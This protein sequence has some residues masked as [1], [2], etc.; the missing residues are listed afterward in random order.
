[1]KRIRIHAHKL[2][3]LAEKCEMTERNAQL[4]T[5]LFAEV[6][7]PSGNRKPLIIDGKQVFDD[8]GNPVTYRPYKKKPMYLDPEITK[9]LAAAMSQN[10]AN[11]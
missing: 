2:V 10:T 8:E 7:V 5:D 9:I 4:R 6:M 11:R 1:M 3:D